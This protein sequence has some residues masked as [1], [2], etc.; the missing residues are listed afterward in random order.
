MVKRHGATL[1]LLVLFAW[2]ACLPAQEPQAAQKQT[3]ALPPGVKALRDLPYVPDGHERQKLDLYLPEKAEGSLPVVVW[4]HGGAWRQGSKDRCP[5]VSFVPK[6]YAA[7]SIN[8]RLSQHAKF[9]AQIEDC[10]EAIRWLRAHAKEYHL[11]NDRFGVWG[12]SAGGHLVA[13]LGASGTVTEWGAK[14][15][16]ADQSCKVQAVCD[17]FGPSDFYRLGGKNPNGDNAL[18]QLIGG[19]VSENKEKADK[20]SPVTYVAKDAPPFLIMHGDKDALVPL[21]Q[22][23]VLTDALKKA[24]VDVSL[25]V[26]SGAGHGGPAFQ[27]EDTRKQVVEFFDKHLKGSVKK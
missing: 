2:L 13:L 8:Y 19:P 22:S 18:A 1:S 3:P 23:E 5:V 7:A 16:H 24:G 17:W 25:I 14:G 6:G 27:S 12:A 10:R 4:V 15:A 11:D 21:S 26:L 9:P 20:A